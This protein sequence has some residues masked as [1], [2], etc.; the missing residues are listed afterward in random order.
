MRG[1]T[2]VKNEKRDNASMETNTNSGWRVTA[3]GG[4]KKEPSSLTFAQVKK[5]IFRAINR[6]RSRA[7]P[8]VV[9]QMDQKRKWEKKGGS[10]GRT[11]GDKF[12]SQSRREVCVS[13][14]ERKS[15]AIQFDLASGV[16]AEAWNI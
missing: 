9:N 2:S 6:K 15:C 14:A 11:H 4:R 5:S 10:C 3:G 8:W 12:S 1:G 13:G 16:G 7:S